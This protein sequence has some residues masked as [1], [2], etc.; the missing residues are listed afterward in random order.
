MCLFILGMVVVF[1]CVD[2]YTKVDLRVRAFSI[3]PQQVTCYT[4]DPF[5]DMLLL[6]YI[7]ESQCCYTW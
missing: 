5:M 1:P 2:S 6:K 4:I 3:P 7:C